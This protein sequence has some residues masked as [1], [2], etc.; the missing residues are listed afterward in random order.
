MF[1]IALHI[2]DSTLHILQCPS[3]A[4]HSGRRT[5]F[6]NTAFPF[7]PPMAHQKD[8][9]QHCTSIFVCFLSD[10]SVLPY[11]PRKVKHV[12]INR[13]KI[14]LFS[15]FFENI[16]QKDGLAVYIEYRKRNQRR[17]FHV[18]LLSENHA[19]AGGRKQFR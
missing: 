3:R 8:T 4:S 1:P 6:G 12:S 16:R 10:H 2:S 15:G 11:S 13:H 17:P 9:H 18:S 14:P 19:P 5:D 7:Q